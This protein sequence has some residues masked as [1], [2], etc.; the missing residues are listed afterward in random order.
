MGQV[1]EIAFK[2]NLVI[3]GLVFQSLA[4]KIQVGC[5]FQQIRL[6]CVQEYSEQIIQLTKDKASANV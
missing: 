3:T 4:D 2:Q 5:L 1:Q 6:N